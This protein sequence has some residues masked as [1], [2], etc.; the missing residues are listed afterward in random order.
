MTSVRTALLGG[1]APPV[2]LLLGGCGGGQAA[3]TLQSASSSSAGGK[4]FQA[5]QNGT[6]AAVVH[7]TDDRK[8]SASST[9]VKIGEVVQFTNSGSTLHNVTSD[10]GIASPVMNGGDIF[11]VKFT[12]PGTTDTPAHLSRSRHGGNHHRHMISCAADGTMAP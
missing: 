12:K 11:Q 4:G 9:R 6:A 2:P 10:A 5:T 7:E 3:P 8:F 1:S